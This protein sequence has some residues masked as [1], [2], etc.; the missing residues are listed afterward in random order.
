VPDWLVA[1]LIGSGGGLV[2]YLLRGWT[3]DQFARTKEARGFRHAD[4]RALRDSLHS[5]LGQPRAHFTWLESNSVHYTGGGSPS[6]EE[7]AQIIASWVY[8]NAARFPP[9]KRAPIYLI[10]NVAY[11]LARGDRHFLDSNPKGHE[12]IHDAWMALDEYAQSLTS[13]LHSPG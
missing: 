11:Q 9:D 13:R 2:G 10:L 6:L 12:A 1:L 7:K 3:D 4:L 5:F 8:E